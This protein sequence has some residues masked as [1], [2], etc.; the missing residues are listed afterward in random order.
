[1]DLL[2][3]LDNQPLII[4]NFAGG[5][6]LYLAWCIELVRPGHLDFDRFRVYV[7]E[8]EV[9]DLLLEPVDFG[10]VYRFGKCA[11]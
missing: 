6:I 1:M 2:V 9:R 4:P 11:S 10:V 5:D 8:E 3:F 7:G